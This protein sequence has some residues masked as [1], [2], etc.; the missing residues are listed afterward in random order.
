MNHQS[1]SDILRVPKIHDV[2][3]LGIHVV[4][5]ENP[6][7][8]A[9]NVA[10]HRQFLL[11]NKNYGNPFELVNLKNYPNFK[12]ALKKAKTIKIFNA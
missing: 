7:L 4:F 12:T 10:I 6:V 2:S 9:Y 5:S 1:Q 3:F 8:M 11:D